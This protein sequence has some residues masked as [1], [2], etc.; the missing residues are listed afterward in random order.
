MSLVSRLAV[1]V[2][3][4]L[5]HGTRTPERCRT[6]LS[7]IDTVRHRINKKIKNLGIALWVFRR[8]G[9]ATFAQYSRNSLK[10]ATRARALRGSPITRNVRGGWARASSRARTH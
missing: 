7:C 8:P 10:L 5:V 6:G 1:S 3:G 9:I 4:R 2:T